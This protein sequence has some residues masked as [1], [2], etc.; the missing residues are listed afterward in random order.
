MTTAKEICEGVPKTL[1][2]S[3]V[4]DLH[5]AVLAHDMEEWEE[6]APFLDFTP[7]EESAIVEKY[8]GRLGLQ[9]REALRMWKKKK[10][11]KASYR[12]LIIVFCVR[13][14]VDL[15]E[16]VKALSLTA[17]EKPPETANNE[18]HITNKAQ[19]GLH[20]SSPAIT[21]IF[22]NYLNDC[23]D[24]PQPPSWPNLDN[25]GY[26]ALDLQEA[27]VKPNAANELENWKPIALE[28]LF[29]AGKS[30]SKRKVILVEGVAGVG[31]TTLSW[32]AV[33]K[34]AKGEIFQDIDLL[35][36]VSL[37]D[38]DVQRA[39]KLADLVPHPSK[40]IRSEVAD[41][42]AE[43]GG[44]KVCFWLDG[45]DEAPPPFW[46]SF[47][48]Q[49]LAGTGGRTK[50]S[51]VSIVLT[52]RPAFAA[53]LSTIL[54]GKVVIKGFQS[55][56]QY[57]A[58]YLPENK[59]QLLEALQMKP[60]LYSICHIPLNAAVM[61][62][63]YDELKD[64][65]PTTRTGLFDP[66]IRHTVLRHMLT[67]TSHTNPNVQN[68]P[69]NLPQDIRSSLCKV[70]SLA[71]T[72]VLTRQNIMPQATLTK[73]GI[74][75][76]FQ[77]FGL[78][79]ARLRFTMYGPNEQFSFVHPSLQEFLAALHITLVDEVLQLKAIQV[80][81]DQNPSSP[82]LTFYAGLTKLAVDKVRDFFLDALNKSYDIISIAKAIESS[83]SH[84][85]VNPNSDPRRHLLC[86]M[87]A[88]YESQNP[89]LFSYVKLCALT[90][91]HRNIL[92]EKA[93]SLRDDKNERARQ[94]DITFSFMYLYPTDC[95]SLGYFV[96]HAC[97]R[98]KAILVYLDLSVALLMNT[99][100]KAL[101][102]ELGKPALS[103]NVCL[104]IR[105]VHLAT[106][107][108]SLHAISTMF[109]PKSCLEGLVIDMIDVEDIQLAMK[110]IVEACARSHC[111][112]LGVGYCPS[113]VI[114]HF[115]LLLMCRLV[116]NLNLN[117][118]FFNLEV[119]T[120]FSEAM[121]HS[122]LNSL[123]LKNCGINDETLMVLGDA[124]CHEQCPLTILDIEQ[125]SYTDD[126]L[127]R[128]INKM[129]R[130]LPYVYLTTLSADNVNDQH[131]KLVDVINSLRQTL[132]LH[133]P[134]LVIGCNTALQRQDNELE[135]T[136]E[137]QL[138]RNDLAIR[139][140]FH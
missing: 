88:L 10:G 15:A 137:S 75:N 125:N 40:R 92:V 74:D 61:I 85:E 115:L 118:L 53:V 32:H 114:H 119:A 86:L 113:R 31:K 62:Y 17:V 11:S 78:L 138:M 110:Y 13:K 123:E 95:L 30:Q 97:S 99:E 46:Q 56:H 106:R 50:L 135:E 107:T 2:D 133:Y 39:T 51:S 98:D 41:A 4:D 18:L 35:I 104:D 102:Q 139:L 60:E 116:E 54:T 94:V 132:L 124:V 81:F 19:P 66:L 76:T 26:V 122:R 80:V 111:R 49:F 90:S 77:G 29:S 1:L 91:S 105:G 93:R 48:Y 127:G 45:L 16:K 27:P 33:K 52:S 72:S 44:K 12:A 55:L 3:Q 112:H 140:P 25:K 100:I 24:I 128:F 134:R 5:L 63:L 42:I 23:Y 126:G 68:F 28:S 64:N 70:S 108:S 117:D 38:P 136:A 21:S 37:G 84:G 9:I 101:T 129:Y 96:R 71:F 36:H 87:N 109:N 79:R 57:I 47:L 6:L 120:L 65:L 20:A 34:W 73:F 82:I 121:K 83:V 58:A 43:S 69:A 8:R 22:R 7:A 59:D 89:G 130:R 131:R 14:R 103:H 67:R